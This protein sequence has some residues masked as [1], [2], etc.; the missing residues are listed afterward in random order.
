MLSR[1][2]QYLVVFG[3]IVCVV[4]LLL[5]V[6]QRLPFLSWVGRLPGDIRI[7]GRNVHFYFPIATCIILSVVL[8]LLVSLLRWLGGR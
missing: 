5:V 1:L 7:E 2:G 8:T 6:A 3:A 4:G